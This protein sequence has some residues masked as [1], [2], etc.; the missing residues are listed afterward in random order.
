MLCALLVFD[1]D[2]FPAPLSRLS[3]WTDQRTGPL[4]DV[5]ARCEAQRHRRL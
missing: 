2:F 1:G 5:L 4:E 3:P